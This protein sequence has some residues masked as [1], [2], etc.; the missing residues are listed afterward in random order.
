MLVHANK[1]KL[2]LLAKNFYNVSRTMLSIYDANKAPI[3]S[4]PHKC[5]TFCAEVRKSIALTERCTE[6][7]CDALRKCDETRAAYTYECHMGLI[8][9]AVPIIQNDIIIGY[10]LFG[11]ITDK[12]DRAPL[13]L[14]L[15]ETAKEYG[16]DYD[17]LKN[18]VK[19]LSYRSPEYITSMS[20]IA[21]MCAAYIWQNSFINLKNDSAAQA[22][23]LYIEENMKEP[24]SV[25]ALCNKFHLSRSALYSLSREY[26]SCGITDYIARRRISRAKELLKAKNLNI[27][28]VAA[29]VGFDDVSYFIRFFKKHTGITPKKY[30]TKM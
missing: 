10:L 27:S 29:E 21:E 26:F 15:K 19:T 17:V 14:G 9:V 25:S 7:D 13:L 20:K 24:M 6:C 3:C 8:E 11:Q 5:C 22:L 30:Q 23:N 2:L 18:G 4:Y 1:K 28:G 16:L 12:K